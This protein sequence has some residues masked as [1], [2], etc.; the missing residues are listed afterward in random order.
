MLK[1][2]PLSIVS[3]NCLADSYS[4]GPCAQPHPEIDVVSWKYRSPLIRRAIEVQDS[5]IVCL[6]EVDHYHDHYRPFLLALGYDVRYIQRQGRQDGILIA[7]KRAKFQLVHKHVIHFDDLAQ[8]TSML[9]PLTTSTL[10]KQNIALALVLRPVISHH[11]DTTASVAKR[12]SD[13]FIVCSTHLYWNPHH[14]YIKL[15]QTH[16]LLE[17]LINI[18]KNIHGDDNDG[19]KG[20]GDAAHAV[21]L[22]GDFNSEPGSKQYAVLSHGRAIKPDGVKDKTRLCVNAVYHMLDRERNQDKIQRNPL[23]DDNGKWLFANMNGELDEDVR[24]LCDATLTKL[25]RWLRLLGINTALEDTESQELRA[26]RNDCNALFHRARIEQRILLTTSKSMLKRNNCP[27][28]YFVRNPGSS[29]DLK[30]TLAALL[31]YYDVA[32]DRSRVFKMCGKC[33]DS[34]VRTDANDRRLRMGGQFVPTDCEIFICSG[35]HKV[36][37]YSERSEASSSKALS[38]ARSL[39]EYVE[40]SRSNSSSCAI[41]K[42]ER[43]KRKTDQE[44]V[45][46]TCRK[47]WLRFQSAFAT[48]HDREPQHTN[49]NGAFRGVLDYIFVAGGV[50]VIKAAIYSRLLMDTESSAE[51]EVDLF[52]NTKWPSD[53]FLLR[54]DVLLETYQKAR[55]KYPRTLSSL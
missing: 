10:R 23:T 8:L 31:N 15:A 46:Q 16:Y 54:A 5:D 49:V 26:A 3:W 25:A 52:P 32:L 45:V 13:A 24:F 11:L 44:S 37:W 4:K 12:S 21:I 30:E 43:T 51:K 20:D 19:Q 40:A 9:R 50:K 38:L 29:N 18:Q 41:L 34:V 14:S 22:T 53:H 33:G 39:T 17:S 28:T 1:H 47:Q 48:V 55:W 36:Y 2:I 35:C 6:Q 42:T 27:E 7:F